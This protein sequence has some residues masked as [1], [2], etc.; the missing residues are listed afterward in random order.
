MTLKLYNTLTRKKQIFKPIKDKEVRMYVC[1][2]TIYDYIHIGNLR[3]YTFSDILRRTLEIN[4]YKI[5]EVMNLTDVDD[6]TIRDSQKAKIK[7]KDF[8]K[9]YEIAFLE[10]LKSMNI[11]KPEVMPKATEH[12]KE[13]VAI[14]KKLLDKGIAYKTDDGIYFSIKKFKNY[15]KLSGIKTK[16]L[17]VGASERV[18]KD[19]YDKENVNDFAL[20]KFY[21]ENDGDVFWDTEIGKGRPGWHIECSAMSMKYL[22]ETFDI[23]TGGVD[24]IFPHH[25]NEIAQSEAANGKKFVNFW[26]HNEWIL[27]DGKKMSKSLGNFYKLSDVTEKDYSPRDLRYFFLSGHYRKPLN[28]TFTNLDN[29]KNTLLRLKEIISKI[30]NSE[31]KI[32]KNNI[33]IAYNQFVEIMNDDLNTPKALS[34]MWEILRDDKLNNSEKYEL[35]LKFDKIFGLKLGEEDKIKIPEKV[36]ELAEKREKARKEKN[37][38]LADELR[39][40]IKAEGYS[41]ADTEKGWEIKK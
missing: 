19:E 23:H 3:A 26:L 18:L 25:E 12:I 37:W 29:S 21:D 10:D 1:G 17:K 36:K 35:V 4:E 15:G 34:Y 2:P 27:V 13:M 30:K 38:K 5:K 22:G 28:F 11:E 8:T 41:I 40:K 14:V 24:L 7:L 6:K 9:K 32:N 20:W 39:E 33:E 16:K 31:D